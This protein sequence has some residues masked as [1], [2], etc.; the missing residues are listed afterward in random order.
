[1]ANLPARRAPA[2]LEG[3]NI[4]PT[5][6]DPASPRLW[7]LGLGLAFFSVASGGGV[8]PRCLPAQD[9][10]GWGEPAGIAGK[11]AKDG[12]FDFD[13]GIRTAL[14]MIEPCPFAL[15]RLWTL[16]DSF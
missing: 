3:W 7:G 15:P 2:S 14:P 11:E 12:A 1:M 5:G 9:R 13:L 16:K 4:A 8:W 10:A 6:H